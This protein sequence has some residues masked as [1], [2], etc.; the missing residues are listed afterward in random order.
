MSLEMAESCLDA[1]VC[2]RAMRGIGLAQL[3][4]IRREVTHGCLEGRM[5]ARQ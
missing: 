1:A 5:N 2:A 4:R 3:L